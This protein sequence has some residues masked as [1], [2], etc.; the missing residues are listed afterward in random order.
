MRCAEKEVRKMGTRTKKEE[1][2][3]GEIGKVS[4]KHKAKVVIRMSLGSQT[5]LS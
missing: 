2:T 3:K 1:R 5:R 4:T